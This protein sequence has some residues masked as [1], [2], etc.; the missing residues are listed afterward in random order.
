MDTSKF[1][2]LS[3]KPTQN[4]KSTILK[5]PTKKEEEREKRNQKEWYQK[6]RERIKCNR[7]KE[8]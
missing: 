2:T 7:I 4:E 1:K 8:R 6:E 5:G 3:V